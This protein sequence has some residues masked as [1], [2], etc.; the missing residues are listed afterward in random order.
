MRSDAMQ[1]LHRIDEVRAR[2]RQWRA[3]GLRV[4]L[5]PTMG[6][7]H[8][9]HL[10]LVE[11]TRTEA[12][13]IV[14]SIFVNPTQFGAGEDFEQY[15][16]TLDQDCTRLRPLGVE[17]VFAPAVAEMYPDGPA[18]RTRVSTP[19]LAETLCGAVRPGHF[20]GVATVVGKLFHIVEPDVAAFGKK[21][22]QQLRVI[23]RMVRDLDM[24]VRILPVETLRE[25]SGLAMSSRNDY[26]T[27]AEKTRA[28]RLRQTLLDAAE[29][30]RRREPVDAVEVWG[31]EALE[32]AGFRTDYFS[33]R[34][35]ADLAGPV[36]GERD[37]VVLAAAWLG[38]TRLIDNLEL[39]LNDGG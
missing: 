14:V 16:R 29:R 39:Q 28:A 30:L 2:V 3:E 4:G 25:P 36:A 24:P 31:R 18:L 33:I 13:C 5:V 21:D 10:Q 1:L 19:Q 7:L 11:A 22:Y 23:Q 27:A 6:N 37:L 12:D 8:R 35:Q 20:D 26:L 38:K 15:P 32:A 17:A 34:R 9:G